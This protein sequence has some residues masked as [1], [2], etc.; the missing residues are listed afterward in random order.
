MTI[1][2]DKELTDKEL[3]DCAEYS[4]QFH[5]MRVRRR[6]TENDHS[7]ISHS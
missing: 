3:T 4:C 6:P 7:I 1:Q 5:E 2:I